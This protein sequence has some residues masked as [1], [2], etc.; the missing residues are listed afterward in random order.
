ML[1][2]TPACRALVGPLTCSRPSAR[3]IVSKEDFEIPA[4]RLIKASVTDHVGQSVSLPSSLVRLVSFTQLS[5][6]RK[7][8]ISNWKKAGLNLLI[9]VLVNDEL[10]NQAVLDIG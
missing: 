5:D 9:I 8:L 4:H 3:S 1:Q 10:L 7:Q 2:T 6:E